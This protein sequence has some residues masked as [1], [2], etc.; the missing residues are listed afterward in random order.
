MKQNKDKIR[1][2]KRQ[3]KGKENGKDK[4]DKE[5]GKDKVLDNDYQQI[6][7]SQTVHPNDK[8]EVLDNDYQETFVSDIALPKRKRDRVKEKRD[9]NRGRI[10]QNRE[11]V[12]TAKRQEKDEAKSYDIDNGKLSRNN[13]GCS[14]FKG[15]V[16]IM[17]RCRNKT[18]M[19]SVS[20]SKC[21]QIAN[22]RR[23]TKL[24]EKLKRYRNDMISK[25]YRSRR[26]KT[27][28][29]ST[30]IFNEKTSHGPIYVCSVCLQT[31]F[32]ISVSNVANIPWTSN[33]QRATYMECTQ[34]YKSVDGKEWLCNTCKAALKKG[35]W[36][37]L[38][39]A[40]GMGFPDI[41]DTLKLYGME[42]WVVSPRLLFFQ[43]QFSFLGSMYTCNR[44][45]SK[46]CC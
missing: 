6:F 43:M 5:N 26:V 14:T 44:T 38:S 10:K 18:K 39:V 8:G 11:K 27:L 2:A 20:T 13:Y 30:N 36:P 41:P 12:R 32:H 19:D 31:W 37:K 40:N 3:K 42:E 29:D 21:S 25:C 16:S 23:K 24:L 46:S 1:K 15:K 28:A 4:R 9:N 45:C 33:I 35:H 22:L 7:V 34:H 17:N